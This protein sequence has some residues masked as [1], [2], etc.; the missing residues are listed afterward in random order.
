MDECAAHGL[1][2]FKFARGFLQ[3]PEVY[4]LSGGRLFP[5]YA[6]KFGP[7]EPEYLRGASKAGYECQRY[8]RLEAENPVERAA[9]YGF[10][11]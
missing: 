9:A 7:S 8:S 6:V 3:C 11:M 4:R 5:K 10:V 2:L 1:Q